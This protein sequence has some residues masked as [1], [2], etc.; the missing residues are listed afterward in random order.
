[1]TEYRPAARGLWLPDVVRETARRGVVL[2]RHLGINPTD[3]VFASYP[4]SGSTWMRFVLV[5]ALTGNDVDFDSVRLLSPPVGTQRGAVAIVPGGGRLIKSHEHPL[6]W[7]GARRRTRVFLLVRDGRDVAVSYFHHLVRQGI[8]PDDLDGFIDSFVAGTVGPFGTWQAHVSRWLDFAAD[9]PQQTAL[10][11]YED[12]RADAASALMSATEH[13]G[14][15]LDEAVI[16]R[17]L[18]ASTP[19]SMRA[20]EA[21]SA[22]LR[23]TT[24]NK[25]NS[26][27]RKA[28]AGGWSS[29][30]TESQ[31]ARIEAV[32]GEP[33]QRLG[34]ALVGS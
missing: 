13:L 8:V 33:L 14:L 10:V 24:V 12:L 6:F 3:L 17:A 29:A 2:K 5:N 15:S 19:D 21:G 26:F 20:K 22:R 32:A 1:M 25:G 31:V 28:T 27:V 9:H 30:L 4:K 18:V 23:T 11:R 7:P 16:R 34:Y